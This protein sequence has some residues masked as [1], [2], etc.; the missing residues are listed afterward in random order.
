MDNVHNLCNIGMQTLSKIAKQLVNI[1]ICGSDFWWMDKKWKGLHNKG[2]YTG[3]S[4]HAIV[5]CMSCIDSSLSGYICNSHNMFWRI[6]S[7]FYYFTLSNI[8]FQQINNHNKNKSIKNYTYVVENRT[9]IL[10]HV[11]RKH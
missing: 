4:S 11:K 7:I 1:E 8:T 10:S 3:R 5:S 2:K 9:R 6:A